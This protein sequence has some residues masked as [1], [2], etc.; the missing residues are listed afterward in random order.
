MKMEREE[1]PL[2]VL[3]I[4]H[5]QAPVE[6]RKQFSFDREQTRRF[7]SRMKEEPGVWGSVLVSTCNRTEVYFS[8]ERKAVDAVQELLAGEKAADIRLLRR[9]FRIYQGQKAAEHLFRVT[10]G[11]DSMVLGEDEI[12]GQIRTAYNTAREEQSADYY[13]NALFQR[14]LKSAKR[15]KTE[16]CLSKSSVSIAT[17]SA[18]Q[19]V[20]F[21][22][23][24]KKVLL[25]G[26][27]GQMGSLIAKNLSG[28]KD[29]RLF[30]AVRRRCPAVLMENAA[31]IAYGERYSYIDQA[32]IVISAT[33]SPHYTITYEAC[34]AAVKT[35]KHRLFLDIAVPN[36]IDPDIALLEGAQL[37]NIDYFQEI[38]NE[39]MS[40]KEE[41]LLQAERLI[42][43][44]C[45]EAEKEL[46][47]HD[48]LPS[49]PG[50]MECLGDK[51]ARQLFYLMKDYAGARE[52]SVLLSLCR[53]LADAQ[54]E[55][56]ET[57]GRDSVI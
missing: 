53:R 44:E 42:E 15:I 56:R 46:I 41:G 20:Q 9:F 49:L 35:Q 19:A 8:G 7:L 26:A 1:I 34:R 28:R 39:H 13:I 11:L 40:Q 18:A 25:L 36:D 33:A 10:G 43:K 48:F 27:T 32:D 54:R 37:R 23:G 30:A 24:E 14:A 50:L 21:R 31:Q 6:I 22:E 17:L 52:L 51:N 12:L 2:F 45:E 38:A 55:D 5:R 57:D 4:S 16:T 47:F 3:S 29:I